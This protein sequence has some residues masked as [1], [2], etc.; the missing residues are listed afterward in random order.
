MDHPTQILVSLFIVYVAALV[1]AEVAQRL[2]LPSVVGQIAAGCAIG[3]SALAWVTPSEPLTVLA[4]IG[5]ILLLFS[6]GLETRLRE[7]RKV[8][9][10]AV[11][12]ALLG[13]AVPFIFGGIWALASGFPTAKAA[14]VAAAFVA[15]SAGITAKVLQELGVLSRMESRIILGAAIIDDVLAMLLLGVVSALQT[16]A[17]V[18]FLNLAM[19]LGQAL[20]FLAAVAFLGAKVMQR[21]S[22]LMEAPVDAE[23]PLSISLAICLGLAAAASQIGLAAIIGAFLA[24]MI[25]AETKHRHDIER[26]T[27]PIMALLLPFFFVVTGSQVDVRLL[28][29]W[30]TVGVVLFV[31]LLAIV[32]KVIGCGLGARSLGRKGA[33]IVGVGMVPRGE[34]GIIVASLGERAGVFNASTYGIIIA[35]S[36]L[37]SVFAPPVLKALLKESR[38]LGVEESI[39]Q[40]EPGVDAS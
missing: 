4:E 20:L 34:V 30:G 12:V 36:L 5:A 9:G 37:T 21:S 28:G 16:K 23:S 38:S 26:D 1:G 18:D 13:V 27:R 40:L 31:T 6:V 3:P 8:G 11:S 33:M 22:K 24:G 17:G 39:P 19:V 10:V 25:L 7:L 15:T 2:G 35:M 14:F 32:A 29:D